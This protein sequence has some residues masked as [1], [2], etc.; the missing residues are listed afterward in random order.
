[1]VLYATLGVCALLLG[2]MVIRYDLYDREP[3]WLL[4]LTAAAGAGVMHGVGALEDL[5]LHQLDIRPDNAGVFAIVVAVEEELGRFLLVGLLA[6]VARKSFNDPMDGLIYGSVAGLGMAV[7]EAVFYIK[8]NSP[9]ALTIPPAEIIR[10]C[11]HMVMGGITCFGL[12]LWRMRTPRW[13]RGLIGCLAFSIAM[14]WLWDYNVLRNTFESEGPAARNIAAV[15]I[16]VGGMLFYGALVIA[17]SDLSRDQF[18][19]H[20]ERSIWDLPF[21]LFVP[22]LRRGD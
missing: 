12:G 13:R 14:H 3:W 18:N 7:N 1:M 9:G 21:S 20:G 10:L 16:I 15:C 5:T 4:L 2:Q 17:G 8:L 22:R 19:A 11:G 6:F